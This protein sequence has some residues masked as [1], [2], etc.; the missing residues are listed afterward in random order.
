M[1]LDFGLM[2]NYRDNL[3]FKGFSSKQISY[4]TFYFIFDRCA[5]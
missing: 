1:F 2:D 5:Y 3:K 4:Y